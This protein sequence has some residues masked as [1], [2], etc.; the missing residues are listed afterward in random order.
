MSAT[1]PDAAQQ[2]RL[3]SCQEASPVKVVR[4]SCVARSLE[5]LARFEAMTADSKLGVNPTFQTAIQST[6]R[7]LV[8]LKEDLSQLGVKLE[9]EKHTRS[10]LNAKLEAADN[11]FREKLDT[12]VNKERAKCAAEL[13]EVTFS[14]D[15][16][17]DERD[18]LSQQLQET[19][20]RN[21]QLVADVARMRQEIVDFKEKAIW[22][23][24]AT[25]AVAELEQR[26]EK[27]LSELIPR[28][29]ELQ[30]EKS[31]AQAHQA[32]VRQ[33]CADMVSAAQQRLLD[34]RKEL[35]IE[36]SN[37]IE[38]HSTLQRLEESILDA[39]NED[40]AFQKD[41]ADIDGAL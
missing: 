18:K 39:V 12:A 2:A 35:A 25:F 28:Q 36:K 31:K 4:D 3:P 23:T 6:Q 15:K 7:M 30:Q 26:A 11:A 13:D 29:Q 34:L 37:S 32:T 5:E 9:D 21:Q 14:V 40:Q 1:V 8:R 41:N 24:K 27:E 10:I 19:V 38:S 17:N 22:E 33:N 16:E 20:N